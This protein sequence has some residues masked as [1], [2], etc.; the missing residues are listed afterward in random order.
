[1][2]CS[3]YQPLGPFYKNKIINRSRKEIDWRLRTFTKLNISAA[4]NH[5]QKAEGY[6]CFKRSINSAW[7]TIV[8]GFFSP[9]EHREIMSWADNCGQ[10]EGSVWNPTHGVKLKAL[11]LHL[12]VDEAWHLQTKRDG[13]TKLRILNKQCWTC[14]WGVFYLMMLRDVGDK[15][16]RRIN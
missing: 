16:P 14:W 11:L 10:G 2:K 6:F 3:L 7:L 9:D 15:T 8:F 13:D 5:L 12:L 4:A 1:M